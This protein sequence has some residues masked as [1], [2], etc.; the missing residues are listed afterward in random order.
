MFVLFDGAPLLEVKFCLGGL[1]K[2]VLCDGAP[3]FELKLDL[4]GGIG[5][6][7]F[8]LGVDVDIGLTWL[9]IAEGGVLIMSGGGSFLTVWLVE[10]KAFDVEACIEVEV[11]AE[12]VE[13]LLIL[14][15]V[16]VNSG[17]R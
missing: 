16:S 15:F 9:G 17:L 13:M 1:E 3:V 14:G 4:G 10:V 11:D 2:F 5:T 7:P 6:L 8:A 12:L